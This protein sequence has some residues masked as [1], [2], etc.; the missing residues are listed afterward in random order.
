MTG[1]WPG[2]GW[3]G[4]GSFTVFEEE[5]ALRTFL[6]AGKTKFSPREADFSGQQTRNFISERER[7]V[8]KL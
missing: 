8:S 5:D 4:R 3:E 6:L 7:V 2:V 1:A